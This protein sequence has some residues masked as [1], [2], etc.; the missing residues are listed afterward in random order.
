MVLKGRDSDAWGWPSSARRTSTVPC[1]AW[2][3]MGNWQSRDSD[4]EDQV[5]KKSKSRLG[6]SIFNGNSRVLKWVGTDVCTMFLAI[7][8]WDIP[9]HTVGLIHTSYIGLMM[10]GRYLWAI[11]HGHPGWSLTPKRKVGWSHTRTLMNANL[12]SIFAPAETMFSGSKMLKAVGGT[13]VSLKSPFIWPFNITELSSNLVDRRTS[14]FLIPHHVLIAQQILFDR[15]FYMVESP[16]CFC[17][18]RS[19]PMVCWSVI[20]Y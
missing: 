5:V 15:H 8:C 3:R 13:H 1:S 7:F 20:V 10:Y 12:H 18:F 11:L 9:L 6:I 4:A 17:W 16:V 2:I 14:S 19:F